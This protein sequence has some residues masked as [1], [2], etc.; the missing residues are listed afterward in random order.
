M[1]NM[2]VGDVTKG[3]KLIFENAPWQVLE[4]NFVK[5]G[6]GNAFL[7]DRLQR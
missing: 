5:P 2:N 3:S 1:G 4:V 7:N 6:K